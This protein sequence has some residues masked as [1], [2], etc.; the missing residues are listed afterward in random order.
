VAAFNA[1][2]RSGDWE[3]FAD[4]FAPDASMAFIGVPAGP[5]LGRAEIARAYAEQPPTDTMTVGA[6]DSTGAVDTVRFTWSAGGSG[7]M[8]LDWQGPLV[9]G[10]QVAFDD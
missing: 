9:T 3:S 10:L 1:A 7:T 2:V 6:V 5:F 8:Q 4:R